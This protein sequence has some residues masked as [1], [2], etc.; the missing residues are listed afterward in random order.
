MKNYNKTWSFSSTPNWAVDPTLYKYS[1][2]IGRIKVDSKFSED[3]YDKIAAFLVAG[4]RA[5]QIWFTTTAYQ[6]YFAFL[7]VYSDTIFSENIAFKIWDASQG[8]VIV[9]TMRCKYNFFFEE[10]GVLDRSQPAILKTRVW[11]SKK[12]Q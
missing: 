8:K 4:T 2:N 10:N 9:A 12:Y 3:S 7:T 5:L 6:E 1:M 11:W